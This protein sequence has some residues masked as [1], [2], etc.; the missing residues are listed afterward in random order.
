MKRTSLLITA[1]LAAIFL[2][3][4]IWPENNRLLETLSA[5]VTTSDSEQQVL[6]GIR[7]FPSTIKVTEVAMR[8]DAVTSRQ[9]ALTFTLFGES[10][11]AK[12]VHSEQVDNPD[13]TQSLIW[14]GNLE[15]HGTLEPA[16]KNWQDPLNAVTLVK[17]GDRITGTI[18]KGRQLYQLRPFSRDRHL[19]LALAPSKMPPELEPG[20]P[21]AKMAPNQAGASAANTTIDVMTVVTQRAVDRYQGDMLAL[22]QLA[23]AEANQGYLNSLIGINL[24][25]VAYQVTDYVPTPLVTLDL[26]RL[27]NP[28]DGYMDDSIVIRDEQRADIVAL[29]DDYGPYAD[30]SYVCGYALQDGSAANSAFAAVN[31]Q[32]VPHLTFT[33]ELGHLQGARHQADGDSKTEPYA[34]AHGYRFNLGTD[35]WSTVVT[36]QCNPSADCPRVNWFSNPNLHY[37][38]VRLGDPDTADNHRMLEMTKEEIS[39]FR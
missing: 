31:Y 7:A 5:P 15:P 27:Q 33:H 29:I 3:Y 16:I 26:R 21:G 36:T 9:Q 6:S 37:N 34:F 13:G 1:L 38:G 19:A 11:S 2:A 17:S 20:V 25:L 23:V 24:R 18:H 30:G 14:Y 39:N 4:W 8:P 32:C 28:A 35:A 22:M 12:V 10:F